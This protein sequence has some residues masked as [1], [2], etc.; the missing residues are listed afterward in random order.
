MQLEALKQTLSQFQGATFAS[1][2]TV[3]VPVLLGGKQNPFQGKIEKQCKSHRVMLFTNKRTNAYDNMVR[4]HLEQAGLDPTSFKL[5][6]LPWGERVPN[7]PFI[8]CKG[9]HYLQCVFLEAG[10]VE[11]RMRETVCL[12]ETNMSLCFLKDEMIQKEQ[13]EG[14]S[15]KTGSEHQGLER[16]KQVIVRTYAVDSIVAIRCMGVELH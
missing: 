1:L 3:T 13:I 15:D 12:S 5:G 9:K 11:Y 16:S 10:N 8:I 6:E 2:D 4:R 7:S 14:L